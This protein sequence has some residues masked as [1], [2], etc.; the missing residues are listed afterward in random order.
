M[1]IYDD[2][3][4]ALDH[5]AGSTDEAVG[6]AV[7]GAQEGDP[8]EVA[9]HATGHFII[10]GDDTGRAETLTEGIFSPGEQYTA[11][12]TFRTLV[13]TAFENPEPFT[14]QEDSVDLPGPSVGEAADAAGDAADPDNW[15]T[16]IKLLA[17]AIVAVGVLYLIR[18][19]VSL[20]AGVSS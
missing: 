11:T 2:V 6:R 17:F 16:Q 18:P 20:A 3:A 4:G 1:G 5:A 7:D 8:G 15:G 10:A 9:K 19:F 12:G 14:N 13:D